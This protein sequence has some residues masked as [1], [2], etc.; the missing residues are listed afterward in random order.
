VGRQRPHD[1]PHL[2]IISRLRHP[3]ISDSWRLSDFAPAGRQRRGGY[4]GMG[5]KA[6]IREQADLG[7]YGWSGGPEQSAQCRIFGQD[8][9]RLALPQ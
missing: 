2:A 9:Y 8:F 6:L 5:D 7:A 1:H 4:E 3:R